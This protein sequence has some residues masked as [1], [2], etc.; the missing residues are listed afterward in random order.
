MK[1]IK[2]Q[3]NSFNCALKYKTKKGFLVSPMLLLASMTQ[4][5]LG[6][7]RDLF[8]QAI[9]SSCP[10]YSSLKPVSELV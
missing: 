6:K 7:S 2:D 3:A 5:S 10:H 4:N 9:N 8:L 1:L